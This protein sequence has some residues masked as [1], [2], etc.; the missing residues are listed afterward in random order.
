[1]YSYFVP[2]AGKL[3]K[4]GEPD[5]SQIAVS[6]INDWQRVSEYINNCCVMKSEI[7]SLVNQFVLEIK[8]FER[9]QCCPHATPLFV[10]L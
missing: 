5:V 3:L 10:R 6:V 2:P 9:A 1:M 4:G 8:L 7:S